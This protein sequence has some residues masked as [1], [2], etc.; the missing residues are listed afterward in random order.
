[1]ANERQAMECGTGPADWTDLGARIA[2][3]ARIAAAVH[4]AER[5]KC[6]AQSGDAESRWAERSLVAS[7]MKPDQTFGRSATSGS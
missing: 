6:I 5:A 4:L 1:M 7:V 3:A 2:R